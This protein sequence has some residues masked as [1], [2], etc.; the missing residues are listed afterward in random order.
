MLRWTNRLKEI[1]IEVL[2]SDDGGIDYPMDDW[3][4]DVD[5]EARVREIREAEFIPRTAPPVARATRASTKRQKLEVAEDDDAALQHE[6][7][8]EFRWSELVKWMS[9]PSHQVQRLEVEHFSFA[10]REK[11]VETRPCPFD[12]CCI[13]ILWVSPEEFVSF[14]KITYCRH[15]YSVKLRNPGWLVEGVPVLYAYH[16]ATFDN[17]RAA[18]YEAP[19][20][21]GPCPETPFRFIRHLVAPEATYISSYLCEFN[22]RTAEACTPTMYTSF[23]SLASD[24]DRNHRE[25]LFTLSGCL[26]RDPLRELMAYQFHP[27]VRL[28][29]RVPDS[30]NDE[31]DSEDDEALFG[32]INY[33][34]DSVP[35]VSKEELEEIVSGLQHLSRWPVG[36]I[37]FAASSTGKCVQ[38]VRQRDEPDWSASVTVISL[39]RHVE[40]LTVRFTNDN[41]LDEIAVLVQAVLTGHDSLNQLCMTVE[42]VSGN[43]KTFFDK[44]TEKISAQT[45][46]GQSSSDLV[47]GS[48]PTEDWGTFKVGLK[49]FGLSFI[50]CPSGG[51]VL[52]TSNRYWDTVV[53]PHLVHNWFH[54]PQEPP[55][56]LIPALVSTELIGIA[57]KAVNQ[58]LAYRKTTN[59]VARH[60]STSSSGV[61]FRLFRRNLVTLAERQEQKGQDDDSPLRF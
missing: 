43:E 47:P 20:P 3:D 26:L 17:F 35:G 16:R 2:Q 46:S 1:L 14:M 7:P 5:S 55:S 12:E 38:L 27:A 23:F 39:N 30:E 19:P 4:P 52:F 48:A 33:P 29:F 54:L 51:S 22:V 31:P 41:S 61:L 15:H 36:E 18:E 8:P 58:G 34:E 24:F 45:S 10:R 21:Q 28:A 40:K 11:K 32:E 60:L 13:D 56:S 59:L 57:V 50:A 6:F 53:S 37:L 44:L 49:Y 9:P 25:I 42:A